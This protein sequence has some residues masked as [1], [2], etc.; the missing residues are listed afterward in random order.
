MIGCGNREQGQSPVSGWKNDTIDRNK[1]IQRERYFGGNVNLKAEE[2]M[3]VKISG[4]LFEI[5][6]LHLGQLGESVQW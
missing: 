1:K 3:K 5:Q 6:H 2:V 4:K